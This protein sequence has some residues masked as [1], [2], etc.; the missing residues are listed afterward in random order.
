LKQ[1]FAELP[2]DAIYE[3]TEGQAI[4]KKSALPGP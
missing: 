2:A 4:K 3:I 1:E